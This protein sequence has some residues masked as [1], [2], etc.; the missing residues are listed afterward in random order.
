ML[1]QLLKLVEQNAG[2]AIVKNQAIPNQFNNAA[3]KEVA[4]QIFNG[5][6]GQVAQGNV[7]QVTSM[8]KGQ[9][10]SSLANNPMVSNMIS[11]VAGTFAQKFGVSPQVAQG[12]AA[13]LLPQVMNQFVTK[14][15]DP[16]D[17]D[18]DLQDMMSSFSGGQGLDVGS[19][20]G[21]VSGGKSGGVGDVLGNLFGG[22]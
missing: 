15:N 11:Q 20:I 4:S 2:D 13:S 19:I 1:D 8:F 7:Q 5:L 18:F 16:N 10:V 3:V 22:K 17:K 14:T 12:I 21:K 9:S 6:Q